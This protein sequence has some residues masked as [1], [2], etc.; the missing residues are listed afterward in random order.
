MPNSPSL[1]LTLSALRH[2]MRQALNRSLGE[3][4]IALSPPQT[5]LLQLVASHSGICAKALAE[6]T[7]RDKATITR[8]LGPLLAQGHILRSADPADGRRQMLS[9]SASGRQL[10]E[11]CVTARRQVHETVFSPLSDAEKVQV[12]TLLEKCLNR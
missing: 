10:A 5:Q 9:L 2:Q 3:Q 1:E 4:G 12:A 11:A 6:R 8:M 7:G